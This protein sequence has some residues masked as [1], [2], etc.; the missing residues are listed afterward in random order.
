MPKPKTPQYK[1]HKELE[2]CNKKGAVLL[3]HNKL[4]RKEKKELELNFIKKH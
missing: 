2:E 4:L 1:I 3:E